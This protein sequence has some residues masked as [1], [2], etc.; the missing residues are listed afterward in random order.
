MEPFT[1]LI[2]CCIVLGAIAGYMAGLLGIGGGLI[3]VPA[4]MYLLQ[5]VLHLPLDLVMP[6]SVA[7]SLSTIIFT[8]LSSFLAHWRLGNLDWQIFLVCA[9]GIAIG[10]ISGAQVAVLLP[11]ETLKNI[12]AALVMFL[13]LRMAFGRNRVSDAR[14]GNGKLVIVGLITGNLSAL[15]GIGGGALLVPALV[16]FRVCMKIAIGCAAAC[17]M[18]IALFGT[19]SFV[20]AGWHNDHLP[21]WSL[22]YV[23]L[24]ATLA[25]VST[26]MLAANK[27]AKMSQR[28]PTQTLKKIFASFLVLVSLRMFLS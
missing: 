19:A 5:T 23:F 2:F 17:G 14:L 3:I 9:I 11:G 21:P 7:T 27:G 28:L 1:I 18:V 22:G 20:L 26:S 25:I 16:W 10:A 8:G 15:L 12:F 13:A 4:L 6:M 24:P